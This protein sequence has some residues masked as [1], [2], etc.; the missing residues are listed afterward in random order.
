M[1]GVPRLRN[2]LD[3]VLRILNNTRTLIVVAPFSKALSNTK[4]LPSPSGTFSLRFSPTRGF[5]PVHLSSSPS[6]SLQHEDSPQSTY[7]F[8]SQILSNARILPSPPIISSLRSPTR[9]FPPVHLSYSPSDSLQ[10][11]DFPLSTEPTLL[12][13][14][15]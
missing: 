6:G 14:M 5:S 13:G 15:G 7:H 11:E 1:C 4:I 2:F 10:R 8:L 9:G 3:N 12:R